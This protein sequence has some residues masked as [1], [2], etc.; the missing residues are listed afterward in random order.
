MSTALDLVKS[1]RKDCARKAYK[2]IGLPYQHTLGNISSG[3]KRYNNWLEHKK[4]TSQRRKL[5]P[6]KYLFNFLKNYCTKSSLHGLRY[7][8][9]PGAHWMERLIWTIVFTFF[10]ICTVVVISKLSSRFQT[11]QTST[12]VETTQY[13][14]SELPFPSVTLCPSNRV[15]WQKALEMEKDIVPVHDLEAVRTY[16][17]LVTRL[18]TLTFG[19]FDKLQFLENRSL[20]VFSGT[21]LGENLTNFL[22][23]VAPTCAE[24]L[25]DCWWR[26]SYRNCCEIFEVQRTEYG[27]CYSFN[28]E[29]ADSDHEMYSKE[30]RPRRSNMMGDWSGIRLV[31]SL[32]KSSQPPNADKAVEVTVFVGDPKS[33]PSSGSNSALGTLSSIGVECPSIYATER[34]LQ[35]DK[36][37]LS[38]KL[39][40]KMEYN[41]NFC[42]TMC[43]RDSA[44][45]QCGC[46]PLFLMPSGP[47]R[48]CVLDDLLCLARENGIFNNYI[49]EKNAYFGNDTVGMNCSCPP[50]CEGY[51]YRYQITHTK[52]RDSIAFNT[53]FIDVHYESASMLRYRM[54]IVYTQ[55][56]LLVSFGG[57]FGLFL[58]GSILSF[59]ELLYH[60]TIGLIGHIFRSTE[61]SGKTA[62]CSK[63]AKSQDDQKP[64]VPTVYRVLPLMDYH[65]NRRTSLYRY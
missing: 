11:A 19:D 9:E 54:D 5:K 65:V 12:V 28:S 13:P 35:L 50:E 23:T 18:S 43:R 21:L 38:C 4:R 32:N 24:F 3:T 14:V 44:I 27:F 17:D 29:T 15:N 53:I 34:I 1:T 6:L 45:K 63:R 10:L 42:L 40:G 61:T 64:S 48:A 41:Q 55:L 31:V 60:L 2:G 36:T 20:E 39:S 37:K 57:V 52:L 51:N 22:Q 49:L 16:R 47:E 8:V 58:G 59:V 56:D 25:S 62:E 7:I 30:L 46:N 26:A 33:W